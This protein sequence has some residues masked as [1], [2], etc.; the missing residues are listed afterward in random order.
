MRD[1]LDDM[2]VAQRDGALAGAR[3]IHVMRDHG[4][5]GAQTRVEIA[6]ERQ[7]LFAGA[8]IQIACRLVGRVGTLDVRNAQA[9]FRREAG[10]MN[11]R[12][13]SPR[14]RNLIG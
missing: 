4:D 7:N 2:A 1:V 9:L 5:R 6:N 11:S 10:L 3:D 14:Q 8:R 13:R 12:R